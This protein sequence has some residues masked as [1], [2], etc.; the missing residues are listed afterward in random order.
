MPYVRLAAEP[1]GTMAAIHGFLDLPAFTYDPQHIQQITA[2]DDCVN[3]MDLHRIRPQLEPP[4]PEP[5]KDLLPV[6]LAAQLASKYAD[7]NA[8]AAGPVRRGDEV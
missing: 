3:G 1:A 4:P 7:I 2:E 8:L 5:W 6:R